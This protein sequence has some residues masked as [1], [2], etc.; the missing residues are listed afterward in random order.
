MNKTIDGKLL[1]EAEIISIGKTLLKKSFKDIPSKSNSLESKG[2]MG[3]FIEEEVY[4]MKPN[5]ESAPDFT[6]A[7]IELKVTPFRMNKDNSISAK[8]RLVLNIINYIEEAKQN[9]FSSSF[10]TKN[11]K[12]YLLFYLWEPNKSPKDFLIMFDYLLT[13]S[14]EDLYIIRRDWETIHKKIIDGKAHEISEADTMYL[15]ACTKGVNSQSLRE[16]FNSKLLAKQRAYSLKTS[17]MTHLLRTQVTESKEHAIRLITDA[18]DLEKQSF[19]SIIYQRLQPFFGIK[20]TEIIKKYGINESKNINEIIVARLLG[21]MGRVSKTEEFL[22]ANIIPKTIRLEKNGKIIESMSFPTFRFEQIVEETWDESELREYFETSKFMFII[23][24]KQADDYVLKD[25]V[26]W[27][28]PIAL[29][30]NEVKKVWIHTQSIV[31]SGM[32][33]KEIKN[34]K[35]HTNFLKKNDNPVMHVRPHAKKKLDKYPLPFNDQLTGL[36]QYTK[37]C[38][39]LNNSFIL[40]I[41]RNKK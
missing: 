23:F 12:I 36:S 34:N 30:D 11:S 10:W 39:W 38:F 5:T 35:Y 27:N 15:A 24:Q 17:Y 7:G 2:S 41:I 26:F 25:I 21:V 14:R 33:V 13:F 6:K 22:K 4:H 29:L 37:H 9:F 8:E 20:S 3:L 31:K 40:K 18:L 28:M 19:E 32:I 16:Q 1:S